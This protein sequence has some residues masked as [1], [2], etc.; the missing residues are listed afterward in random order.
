MTRAWPLLLLCACGD[1]GAAPPD[2]PRADARAD[3]PADAQHAN[4][5]VIAVFE[6]K[7]S[8]VTFMA[9]AFGTDLVVI[10]SSRTEGPCVVQRSMVG[11]MLRVSAGTLTVSSGSAAPVTLP[12]DPMGYFNMVTGLTYPAGDPLTISA[13][14]GVVPAFS[15]QLAF[16]AYVTVTSAAPTVLRKSG[17]TATWNGTTSPVEITILQYPMNVPGLGIACTFDGAAGTG[18]VPAAALTD[19]VM[20]VSATV[21]VS[22]VVKM[23]NTSGDYPVDLRAQYVAQQT[24]NLSVQP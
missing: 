4:T 10:V 20:G 19:L 1:D 21:N 6:Q 22:T 3:A 15:F 5:G 7:P 12:F 9:G 8:N 14:G 11:S 24:S 17:F 18:T 13:T 2:A 16:P 23:P